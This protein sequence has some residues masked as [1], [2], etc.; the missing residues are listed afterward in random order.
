MAQIF[1]FKFLN[2]AQIHLYDEYEKCISDKFK[3]SQGRWDGIDVIC[4]ELD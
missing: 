2:I 3:K 4:K 1:F